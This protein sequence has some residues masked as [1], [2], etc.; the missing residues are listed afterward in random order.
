MRRALGV[1]AVVLALALLM[2]GCGRP[3]TAKPTL[4]FTLQ[5]QGTNLVVQIDTGSFRIPGDGHPHLRLDGGPEVML[6]GKTYTIPNV[7]PGKHAVSIELSNVQH[8]M[9][10]VKLEKVIEIK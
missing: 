1:F 8:E 9:L 7:K 2:T 6:Y 5:Q 10:G 3:A 4:D